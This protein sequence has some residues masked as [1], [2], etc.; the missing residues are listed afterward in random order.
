M[1]Y[2]ALLPMPRT[3]S[4]GSAPTAARASKAWSEGLGTDSFDGSKEGQDG[5]VKAD[6]DGFVKQ[7]RGHPDKEMLSF[8]LGV[9][10]LWSAP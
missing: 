3:A 2:H 4:S 6:V 9:Y 8:L 1:Q 7:T 10:L 5:L